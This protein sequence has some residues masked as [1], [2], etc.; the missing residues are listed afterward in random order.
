[1]DATSLGN[2]PG[3][4]EVEALLRKNLTTKQ[5]LKALEE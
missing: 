3:G 2:L 4:N 1:M 5:R